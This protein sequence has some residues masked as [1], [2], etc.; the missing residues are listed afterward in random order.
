MAVSK[1]ASLIKKLKNKDI[2]TFGNPSIRE[3]EHRLNK[4]QSGPGWVVRRLHQ[5]ALPVWAGNI[6]HGETLWLPNSS[7]T[8]RLMRTGRLVLLG[9]AKSPPEGSIIVDSE[10]EP[11]DEE[12]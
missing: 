5:K 7:F 9:R 4:W 1:R 2:P 3:L 8:K 11:E 6:P 12:E 10:P